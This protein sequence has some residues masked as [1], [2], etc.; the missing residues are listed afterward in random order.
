MK[1]SGDE[2]PG[3][4]S[5]FLHGVIRLHQC[6]ETLQPTLFMYGATTDALGLHIQ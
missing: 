6:A 5:F 3:H 2:S 4:L 1:Q